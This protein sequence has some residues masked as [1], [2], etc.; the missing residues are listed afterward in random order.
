MWAIH[1][2]EQTL[3]N[4]KE[5]KVDVRFGKS[6]M[7]VFLIHL[8]GDIHQPLHNTSRVSKEHPKGDKGGNEFKIQTS[9]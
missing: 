1:E 5:S 2:C 8:V 9:S 3:Y 6:F 7:L 4:K